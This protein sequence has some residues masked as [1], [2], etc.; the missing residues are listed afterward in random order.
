MMNNHASS[1]GLELGVRGAK[2]S[3]DEVI[4]VAVQPC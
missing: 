4:V 2:R 3:P 1:I